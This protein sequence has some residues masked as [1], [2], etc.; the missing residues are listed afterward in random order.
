MGHTNTQTHTHTHI[1]THTQTHTHTHTHTRTQAQTRHINTHTQVHTHTHTQTNTY[2]LN[3]WVINWTYIRQ[4]SFFISRIYIFTYI[5][6][7]NN[8]YTDTMI[9]TGIHIHISKL[10]RK[11]HTLLTNTNT[12][13]YTLKDNTK[14]KHKVYVS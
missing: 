14:E 11:M 6:L 1:D 5:Q 3:G 8:T 12:H 4:V 13:K 7:N 2:I 9:H 10:A